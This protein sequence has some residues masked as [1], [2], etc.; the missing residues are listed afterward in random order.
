LLDFVDAFFATFA[1]F[2]ANGVLALGFLAAFVLFFTEVFLTAGFLVAVFLAVFFFETTFLAADFFATS[3]TGAEGCADG[4]AGVVVAAALGFFVLFFFNAAPAFGVLDFLASF[5]AF[6]FF[7][8]GEAGFFGLAAFFTF[9][10]DSPILN[11]PLAPTP[12]N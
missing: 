1:F 7:A 8:F 5:F 9:F 2:A 3:A 6:G 10:L 4:A 11:D 12:F